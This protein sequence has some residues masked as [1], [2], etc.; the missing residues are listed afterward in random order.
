MVNSYERQSYDWNSHPDNV[1][2]PQFCIFHF[3]FCILKLTLGQF[4]NLTFVI[5]LGERL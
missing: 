2:I 3:D 5:A 1:G 4:E